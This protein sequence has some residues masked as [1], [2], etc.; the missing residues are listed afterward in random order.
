MKAN[1]QLFFGFTIQST[2]R[3]YYECKITMESLNSN[4]QNGYLSNTTANSTA[5]HEYRCII[6]R[7]FSQRLK[8]IPDYFRRLKY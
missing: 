2:Y 8:I 1:D 6:N 5:N 3:D 4:L 7:A